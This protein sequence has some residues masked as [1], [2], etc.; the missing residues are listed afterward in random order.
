VDAAKSA[1]PEDDR[2]EAVARRRSPRLMRPRG[3]DLRFDAD[4]RLALSVVFSICVSNMSSA[5]TSAAVC[6]FGSI[7]SSSRSD[8]PSTI[9]IT[10]R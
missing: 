9:A 4:A 7:S 6:T 5:W 3:F 2:L 10:S 1:G 8:A